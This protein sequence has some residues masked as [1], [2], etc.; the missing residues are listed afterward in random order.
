MSH[1]FRFA[2]WILALPAGLLAGAI[3]WLSASIVLD[4]FGVEFPSWLFFLVMAYAWMA[5]GFVFA[6]TATKLAPGA[7]T[8]VAQVM[9]A[10][11]LAGALLIVM[12]GEYGIAASVVFGLSLLAGAVGYALRLRGFT[13]PVSAGA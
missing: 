3:V 9:V 4:V 8:R 2:R 6:G 1:L 5:A 13:E 12:R 7:R 10:I 11:S